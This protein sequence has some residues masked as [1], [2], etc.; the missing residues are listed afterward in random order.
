MFSTYIFI[1]AKKIFFFSNQHSSL[2][3]SYRLW[4]R[5]IYFLV[6]L[7]LNELNIELKWNILCTENFP[8]EQ[9]VKKV[10]NWKTFFAMNYL[11]ILGARSFIRLWW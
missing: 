11:S 8:E 3:N 10:E 1:H 2:G 6:I 7:I 4:D 9:T 5:P